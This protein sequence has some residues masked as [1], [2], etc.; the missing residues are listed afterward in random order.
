MPFGSTAAHEPAGSE[1]LWVEVEAPG[2]DHEQI[3]NDWDERPGTNGNA[4]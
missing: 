3:Q 1:I 2:R 4:L